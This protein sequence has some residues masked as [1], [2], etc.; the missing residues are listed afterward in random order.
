MGKVEAAQGVWCLVSPME[1][2]K[3]IILEVSDKTCSFSCLGTRPFPFLE[4]KETL[5]VLVPLVPL[6]PLKRDSGGKE[7]SAQ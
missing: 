4:Q 1:A 6:V 2:W 3:D 5:G 7:I